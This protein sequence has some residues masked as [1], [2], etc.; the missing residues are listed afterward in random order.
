MG[1]GGLPRWR[2]SQR[3]LLGVSFL[4]FY[5]LSCFDLIFYDL[6][7]FDNGPKLGETTRI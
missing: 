2:K 7:C 1:G 3:R 6:S 5:D 4:I